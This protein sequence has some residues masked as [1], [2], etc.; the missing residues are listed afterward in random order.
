M[1]DKEPGWDEE[2][3]KDTIPIPLHLA[4]KYKVIKNLPEIHLSNQFISALLEWEKGMWSDI[5]FDSRPAEGY[6]YQ[7]IYISAEK[8]KQY[9][10]AKLKLKQ[11]PKEG[12]RLKI[13]EVIICILY[14]RLI[15]RKEF[16]VKI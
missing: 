14:E 15:E 16:T 8:A 12:T 1:K 4:E 6:M 2:S 9:R 13:G 5:K 7:H 10:V 3:F 11:L